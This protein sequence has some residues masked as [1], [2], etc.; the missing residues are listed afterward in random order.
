M[1]E[2][3]QYTFPVPLEDVA[4]ASLHANE[5]AIT[6]MRYIRKALEEGTFVR[7]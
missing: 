1:F 3:Q 2:D 7:S 5:K 4:D 6:Y